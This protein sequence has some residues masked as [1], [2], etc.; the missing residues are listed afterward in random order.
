MATST[1]NNRF[2]FILKRSF[3]LLL[4]LAMSA[5]FFY[6]A[7]SKLYSIEAFEWTF[8]DIGISNYTIATIFARL[9]IGLEFAIG[10]F[11]LFHIYLSKVTYPIT[12]GLLSIFTIYLIILLAVNGNKGD[13]GCFGEELPMTPL[14]GILKNVVMIVVTLILMAIYKVKTKS[15][16]LYTGMVLVMGALVVPFVIYPLSIGSQPM[17]VDKEIDLDALYENDIKPDVELREGKHIISFM[18]LT[19]P[20]CRKAAKIFHILK[21]RYPEYPIQFVLTGHKDHEESFFEETSSR[22]VPHIILKDKAAFIEMAGSSVPAIY[23]VNNSRIEYKGNYMQLDPAVI[24][25]W[26]KQ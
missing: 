9:L 10:A 14:Q 25:D 22:N 24:E 5:V 21:K 15:W 3:G 2:L 6:S 16:Q 8:V 20:H 4:L 26:L 12:I 23:W 11:L 1:P 18:S 17:Q 13:C 19:C 7:S